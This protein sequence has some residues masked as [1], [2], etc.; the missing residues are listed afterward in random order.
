VRYLASAR[1]HASDYV[2]A[3]VPPG[4]KRV[5]GV[6]TITDAGRAGVGPRPIAVNVDPRETDPARMSVDD[7]Q[8]AVTR[9]KEA[10]GDDS[11]VEAR[12][13]EDRQH[14]WQYAMT[15]MAVLLAIE[16]IVASRTA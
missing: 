9:L 13:Q 3:D 12:Q 2:I 8:S 1:A 16:G 11:R 5:P 10:G 14:L 7:F 4:V 6:V 15:L